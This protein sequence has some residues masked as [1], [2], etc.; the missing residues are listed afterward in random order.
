ML[1]QGNTFPSPSQGLLSLLLD[2]LSH[3]SDLFLPWQ[4]PGYY[5]HPDLTIS[6]RLDFT[7]R[8]CLLSQNP[9]MWETVP[10]LRIFRLIVFEFSE[11]L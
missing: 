1:S 10:F 8:K 6:D 11:I 2:F 7:F 3:T 9:H 4:E 5:E